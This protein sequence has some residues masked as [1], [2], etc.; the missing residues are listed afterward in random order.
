VTV[1]ARGTPAPAI[2]VADDDTVERADVADILRLE[3]YVVTEA[4]DGDAALGLLGTDRFD[5]LVLDNRMPGHDGLAV[6]AAAVDPPPAVIMS[7]RALEPGRG[8]DLAIRGIAF[9]HKPVEPE[10]LLD[11]VATAVGR[12]RPGAEPVRASGTPFVG[13]VAGDADTEPRR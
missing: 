13:P 8:K 11:A 7:G 10:H 5:A 6:L 4:D 2:L 9:V 3:G 1:T 12:R